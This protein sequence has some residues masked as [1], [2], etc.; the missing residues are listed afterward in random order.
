MYNALENTL[1]TK[2]LPIA[3]RRALETI[4][5]ECGA[6]TFVSK[7][8]DNSDPIKIVINE[9][10]VSIGKLISTTLYK[11]ANNVVRWRFMC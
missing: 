11:S 1:L 3:T 2:F 9:D 8:Q 6:N 5:E 7:R 4:I 10:S